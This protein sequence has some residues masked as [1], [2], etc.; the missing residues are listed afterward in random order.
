V[1]YISVRFRR[2]D[3]LCR[4]T[5]GFRTLAHSWR[6]IRTV[7]LNVRAVINYTVVIPYYENQFDDGGGRRGG[8]R[9]VC[10][11]VLS[12]LQI[13]FCDR[14]A[15]RALC[16]IWAPPQNVE[17]KHLQPAPA[18]WCFPFCAATEI[19]F[20]L[21]GEAKLCAVCRPCPRARCV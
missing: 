1:R 2:A 13:I 17:L 11:A 8:C 19:L 16:P 5:F 4:T 3:G 18:R 12:G 10:H 20:Q 6:D 15:G 21:F 7:C 9:K 14:P